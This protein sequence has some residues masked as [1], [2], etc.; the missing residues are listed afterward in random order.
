MRIG[1]LKRVP[2]P[3]PWKHESADF[4]TWLENNLD[5]I[6]DVL[7]I[8]LSNPQRDKPTGTFTIDLVDYEDL[9]QIAVRYKVS[10]RP[11]GALQ[12]GACATQRYCR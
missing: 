10:C 7:R 8:N 1:K 3:K 11:G 6:N 2:L 12:G 4:T 9:D 5:V